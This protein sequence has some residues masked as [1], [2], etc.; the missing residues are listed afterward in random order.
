M[1][2]SNN[3]FFSGPFLLSFMRGSFGKRIGECFYI[4]TES[5]TSANWRE[6]SIVW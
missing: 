6:L 2:Q 5:F 3:K 4:H 1:Q